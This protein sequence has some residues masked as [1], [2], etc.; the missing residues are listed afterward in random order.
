[1]VNTR[2]LFALIAVVAM[3]FVANTEAHHDGD[4]HHCLN[5]FNLDIECART[6]LISFDKCLHLNEGI[7]W[8][9]KDSMRD[10]AKACCYFDSITP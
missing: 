1:M 4:H 6:C 5:D 10:C 8:P 3:V 2:S 9:C 7:A